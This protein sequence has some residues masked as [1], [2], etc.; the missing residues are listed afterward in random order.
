MDSRDLEL[1]AEQ[2]RQSRFRE[3][4][5]QQSRGISIGAIGNRNANGRHDIYP[6][7]GG[8]EPGRGLKTFDAKTTAGDLVATTPRSDGLIVLHGPK[9]SSAELG[10]NVLAGNALDDKCGN[11]LEGQIFSCA[12]AD[13]ET[14]IAWAIGYWETTTTLYPYL[15]NLTTG[16]SWLLSSAPKTIQPCAAPPAGFPPP[17]PPAPPLSIDQPWY[18]HIWHNTPMWPGPPG[19]LCGS[20]FP[21]VPPNYVLFQGG[22]VNTL[23]TTDGRIWDY[24]NEIYSI[25]NPNAGPNDPINISVGTSS[26]ITYSQS[27]TPP[28]IPTAAFA[29][30]STGLV[31]SG[32][33]GSYL[34]VNGTA[35]SGPAPWR[36]VSGGCQPVANYDPPT[37]LDSRSPTGLPIP[38]TIEMT[39]SIGPDLI[40]IAF[41]RHTPN[42]VSP[43]VWQ[44]EKSTRIVNDAPV[45]ISGRLTSDWR[46]TTPT[47]P[48]QPT[49]APEA[50]TNVSTTRD[51]LWS[52][53]PPDRPGPIAANG[54]TASIKVTEKQINPANCASSTTLRS[55][56][57]AARNG[58]YNDLTIASIAVQW[59]K[60]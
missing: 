1:R 8:K 17:Q 56:E 58:Q 45:I 41:L 9:A 60:R 46:H 28:A 47:F 35:Q 59:I 37:P 25:P 18:Q 16:E 39:V 57:F 53:E 32:W 44:Y 40:P 23:R 29:V 27:P 31:S 10:E 20:I 55:K 42:C 4:A 38:N 15:I 6:I 43:G 26:L 12:Q 36:Y 48:C 21:P 24:R 50:F 34:A 54:G 49:F 33:S 14:F 19:P 52:I 3:N 51:R 11:Y 22:F 7:A 13:R 30:I 2:R 5:A